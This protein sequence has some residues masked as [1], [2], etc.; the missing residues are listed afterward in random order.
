MNN[1]LAAKSGSGI[2]CGRKP[3]DG[4]HRVVFTLSDALYLY[5]C[6]VFT[7]VS[8]L[9]RAEC[10]EHQCIYALCDTS[11]AP[12]TR[13]GAHRPPF[14]RRRSLLGVHT[15]TRVRRVRRPLPGVAVQVHV[16]VEHGG[17]LSHRARGVCRVADYTPRLM[18]C[19]GSLMRQLRSVSSRWARPVSAENK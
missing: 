6:V 3:D 14:T 9:M 12:S 10:F 19:D 17:A 7:P 11:Y 5:V 13:V 15:A 18:R 8:D 1:R 4:F 16:S 2:Y